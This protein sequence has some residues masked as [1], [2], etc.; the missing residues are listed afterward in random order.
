MKRA[1][2]ILMHRGM[3][4]GEQHVSPIKNKNLDT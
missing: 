2:T 4:N 3:T 1:C